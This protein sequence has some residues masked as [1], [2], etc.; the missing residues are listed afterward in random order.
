[1]IVLQSLYYTGIQQVPEGCKCHQ[2]S[3]AHYPCSTW[4]PNDAQRAAKFMNKGIW[5]TYLVRSI[6]LRGIMLAGK[7]LPNHHMYYYHDD[8]PDRSCEPLNVASL[9]FWPGEKFLVTTFEEELF[10]D[11]RWD[12]ITKAGAKVCTNVTEDWVK[13]GI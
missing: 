6:D 8:Q 13:N 11:A 7:S 10:T 4:P 2:D 5:L 12:G 1:M 3:L 9:K